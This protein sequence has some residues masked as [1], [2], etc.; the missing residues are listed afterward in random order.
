MEGSS[1]IVGERHWWCNWIAQKKKENSG[2]CAECCVCY[3]RRIMTQTKEKLLC[4]YKCHSNFFFLHKLSLHV[5][6]TLHCVLF[7]L[8]YQIWVIAIHAEKV[9]IAVNET[10]SFPGRGLWAWCQNHCMTLMIKQSNLHI[11]NKRSVFTSSWSYI[12]RSMLCTNQK[13]LETMLEIIMRPRK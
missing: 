10:W 8:T 1:S 6:V 9:R 11:D 2:T 5:S 4:V 12:E 7:S 3:S 13:Q